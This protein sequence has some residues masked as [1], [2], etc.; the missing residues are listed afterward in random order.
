MFISGERKRTFYK[1]SHETCYT[2]FLLILIIFYQV[3]VPKIYYH[4]WDTLLYDP[5]SSVSEV[6]VLW[7]LTRINF[8]DVENSKGVILFRSL[9][10]FSLWE[11]IHP[12]FH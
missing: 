12:D 5:I 11:I 2:A 10:V 9:T 8:E 6:W 1:L 3:L 7:V 4:Q